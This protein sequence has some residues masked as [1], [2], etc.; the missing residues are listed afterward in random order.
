MFPYEHS[1]HPD[2]N[3]S[4]A[5][6]EVWLQQIK[7]KWRENGRI[8]DA[9]K[10]LS[11]ECQDLLDHIF[12]LDERR[13]MSI[14]SIRSH[15]WFSLPMSTKYETALKKCEAVQEEI[16]KAVATYSKSTNDRRDQTLHDLIS[17]CSV[18][19]QRGDEIERIAMT[20]V[21]KSYKFTRAEII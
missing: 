17:K 16:N 13:R 3:T 10:R 15:P 1:E 5:Q 6:I 19:G 9:A 7:S 4:A 20:R 8:R 2:P 18:V 11:P 21:N 14:E 12:D